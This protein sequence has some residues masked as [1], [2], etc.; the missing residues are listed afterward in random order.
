LSDAKRKAHP[1]NNN[2]R[3]SLLP[4]HQKKIR[5]SL[6]QVPLSRQPSPLHKCLGVV[7]MS[8]EPEQRTILQSS[9]VSQNIDSAGGGVVVCS[10]ETSTRDMVDQFMSRVMGIWN[11]SALMEFISPSG[12]QLGLQWTGYTPIPLSLILIVENN[13]LLLLQLVVIPSIVL[14]SLL[15]QMGVLEL[16]CRILSIM[17][18]L[19][20]YVKKLQCFLKYSLSQRSPNILFTLSPSPCPLP[21]T[22]LLLESHLLDLSSVLG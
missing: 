11:T 17:L 4:L 13:C 20:G 1:L 2:P 6:N 9:T 10:R 5:K 3:I 14:K 19:F 12:R 7:S 8:S 21:H 22:T 15:F 18:L 16:Q